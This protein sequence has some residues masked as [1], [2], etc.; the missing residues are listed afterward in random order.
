MTVFFPRA[1]HLLPLAAVLVAL[2]AAPTLAGPAGASGGR[3]AKDA[4]DDKDARADV[5]LTVSPHVLFQG[6]A[7]RGRVR[8]EPDPQNRAMHIEVDGGDYFS[9]STVELDG[10]QAP[11]LWERLWKGLPVGRYRVHVTVLHAS[12]ETHTTYREFTVVDPRGEDP[13]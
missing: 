13:E 12:G 5:S 3:V 9:S 7:V 4:K 8:L 6:G 1:R 10:D 11:I 2:V